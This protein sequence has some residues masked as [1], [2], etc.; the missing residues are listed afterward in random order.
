[1]P[2]MEAMAMG[3]PTLTAD[4]YGTLEIAQDAAVLVNP[5]SVDDIAHGI[6]RL[7][8]DGELRAQLSQVGHLRAQSFTW[9][10][11]AAQ[12]MSVLEAISEGASTNARNMSSLP[13]ISSDMAAFTK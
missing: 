6:G 3:C 10:S 1:M 5:E 4:R 8:D 2:L 11:T 12:I 7:L 9:Q 13:L